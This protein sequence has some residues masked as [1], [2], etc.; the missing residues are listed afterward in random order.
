MSK[1]DLG[2]NRLHP[3][4]IIYDVSYTRWLGA[5]LLPSA[6]GEVLLEVEHGLLPVGVLAE[7]TSREGQRLV[8]LTSINTHP[9]PSVSPSPHPYQTLCRGDGAYLGEGA[10]EV[11]HERL[12]VVVPPGCQR[13]LAAE[14]EVL[15]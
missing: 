3:P 6:D 8:Q 14:L 9:L 4:D 15:L 11:G 2:I 13:E 12:H 10:V 5:Y 1:Y 7:R